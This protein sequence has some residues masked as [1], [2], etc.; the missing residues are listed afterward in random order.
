M[1]NSAENQAGIVARYDGWA[2][3]YDE[4]LTAPL[5]E[6]IQAHL[7]RLVGPGRGLCVDLGCGTGVHL[8]VLGSLGWSVIGVDLSA[9]Q[10]R[11]ASNRWSLLVQADVCDLPIASERL[12]CCVSALT[13]TDLDDVGPFFA[14]T[15]RVLARSGRL[16]VI[17]THPCFVGPFVT[18]EGSAE[19]VARVHPGYR[20]TRRT[21]VGPGIGQGIRSRVGVRHVPLAELLN[22]LVEAGLQLVRVDEL[23]D[24]TVPW[25]FAFVASKP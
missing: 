22:K 21:F 20:E 12:E 6:E 14:E 2:E 23:G 5:Y 10:L 17:A 18:M 3:W 1:D 8:A 19:G 15:F 11:L 7:A 13:L 4:Y 25:L 24:G 9:D 16:V